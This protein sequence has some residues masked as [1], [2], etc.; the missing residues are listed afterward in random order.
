[1]HKESQEQQALFRWAKLQKGTMPELELLYHVPNGGKRNL[2][3][4]VR[5]KAEGVRAGIP[6]LFLPVPRGGHHGMYIELKAGKNKPT[7]MQLWWIEKLK[8]QGYQV[9]VCYGWEEAKDKILSYLGG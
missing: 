3:E 8:Q 2:Y 9:C 4:A 7:D 1:M 5:L 6:D